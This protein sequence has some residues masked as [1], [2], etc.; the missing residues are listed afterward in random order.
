MKTSLA[1][2]IPEEK[3]GVHSVIVCVVGVWARGVGWFGVAPKSCSPRSFDSRGKLF[4]GPKTLFDRVERGTE[5][6]GTKHDTIGKHHQLDSSRESVLGAVV[7]SLTFCCFSRERLLVAFFCSRGLPFFVA[8]DTLLDLQRQQ[9]APSL[10]TRVPT[11][12]LEEV[13]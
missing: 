3:W 4:V 11:I 9:S 10:E 12:V 13:Q 6:R 8:P 1:D 2:R 5:E 7:F